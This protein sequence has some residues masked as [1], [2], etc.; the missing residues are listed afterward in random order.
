MSP[1]ETLNKYSVVVGQSVQDS[2]KEVWSVR[3][4]HERHAFWFETSISNH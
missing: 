3:Q 4:G 1:R 2:P